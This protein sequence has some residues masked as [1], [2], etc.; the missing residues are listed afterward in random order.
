VS[1]D[2]ERRRFWRGGASP[3]FVIALLAALGGG[4]YVTHRSDA[5]ANAMTN[6]QARALG[7]ARSRY[8]ALLER[9]ITHDEDRTRDDIDHL[10]REIEGRKP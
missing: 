7:E 4:G 6:E 10:R 5:E 2:Q 8:E 3:G 9:C 1:G